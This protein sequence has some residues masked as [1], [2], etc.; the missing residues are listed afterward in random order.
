PA[1]S[2]DRRLQ[3]SIAIHII[4]VDET[5]GVS[6]ERS[7]QAGIMLELTS[8]LPEMTLEPMPEECDTCVLVEYELPAQGISDSGWLK[9]PVLLASIENY[10]AATLGPHFPPDTVIGLRRSATPYAPAHS[11]AVTADGRVWT[12][13]ATE[14]QVSLPTEADPDRPELSLLADLPLA[15][16]QDQY[17]VE[18]L[19][20]PLETL[21][22]QQGDNTWQGLI[23]C[24]ELSL[25]NTLLPLYLRLD[26]DLVEKTAPVTLPEPPPLFPLSALVDYRR[27]DGAQLTLL[28]D[29]TLIGLDTAGA[30]FTGTLT[31]TQPISLTTTLVKSNLLQPGLKTFD[32]DP[33]A[34]SPRT[35]LVVR[36][37]DGLLDGQWITLPDNEIFA[38]LD[39]LLAAVVGIPAPVDTETPT[40]TETPS[41]TDTAV[42]PSPE[43]TAVPSPTI[44][45]FPTP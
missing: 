38:E 24:P 23:V 19:G 11:I 25:P 13:L 27:A 28:A 15:E 9:D 40:G 17:A 7:N 34:T 12:W 37:P 18:C 3:G 44:E 39:A 22:L 32:T 31:T 45:I 43:Q 5:T 35:V 30:I 2:L 6:R 4:T 41:G 10:L 21:Y 8:A 14:A 29:S 1:R 20:S 16:F 36:G 33:T 26:R 42:T